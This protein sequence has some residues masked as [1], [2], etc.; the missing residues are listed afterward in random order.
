MHD[1]ARR[2]QEGRIS[3]AE[4][5]ELDSYVKVGD[6]LALLQSKARRTLK[7]RKIA[8]SRHG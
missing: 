3:P 7:R 4:L 1:L 2:N 6:L 8:T 5:A